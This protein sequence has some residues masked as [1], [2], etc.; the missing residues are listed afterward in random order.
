MIKS[1]SYSERVDRAQAPINP[2]SSSQTPLRMSLKQLYGGTIIN[3]RPNGKPENWRGYSGTNVMLRIF[4]KGKMQD[5]DLDRVH[6][7]KCLDCIVPDYNPG[8]TPCLCT[9]PLQCAAVY[10][11]I[12]DNAKMGYKPGEKIRKK[13]PQLEDSFYA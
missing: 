8:I 4:L 12:T 5:V 7:E 10:P 6:T 1:D 3:L 11:D 9:D 13:Y 2:D